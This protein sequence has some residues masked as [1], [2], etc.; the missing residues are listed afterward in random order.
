V[1]ATQTGIAGPLIS[2]QRKEFALFVELCGQGID[3]GPEI[4]RYLEIIALVAGD[5]D[6]RP[7]LGKMEIVARRTRT[8][9]FATL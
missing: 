4:V 3:L 7:V 9:G 2:R 6:K 5:I 8:N 1:I